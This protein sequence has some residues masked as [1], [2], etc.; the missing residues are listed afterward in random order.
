AA[1]T[2]FGAIQGLSGGGAEGLRVIREYLRPM[3]GDTVKKIRRL[4]E[5]LED[6][7]FARREAAARDLLEVGPEAA[8][9]LER[10]LEKGPTLDARRRA[11]ELLR[12]YRLAPMG[13]RLRAVR[14]IEVLERMATPAA[15]EVLKE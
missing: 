13:H 7:R 6:R 15:R 5:Q 12:S 1:F 3:K 9:E 2:A 8:P 11:E 14:A 10:L 4:V